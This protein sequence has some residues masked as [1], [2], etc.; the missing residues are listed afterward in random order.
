MALR[1]AESGP[2]DAETIVFLH[3]A[4]E[5]GAMWLPQMDALDEYHCLAPDL[6]GHGASRRTVWRSFQE[7]A[8]LVAELISECAPSGR[9][10]VVGLSLGGYLALELL[11]AHPQILDRVVVSGVHARP[12]PRARL[13]G[14]LAVLA[15]P[16]QRSRMAPTAFVRITRQAVR[17]RLPDLSGA[18]QPT[19]VVAGER[20]R[21]LIRDSVADVVAA[22]PD[23]A[24]GIVSGVGHLWNRESPELFNALVRGWLRGDALPKRL[25]M[26]P[27]SHV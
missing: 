27:Q 19:L 2:Q 26:L 6:P 3:G 14:L 16:M 11:A 13:V 1:I 25:A 24:G 5:S 15:A 7:S 23:A 18:S 17:Y 12:F 8:G 10:H 20:E 22:L 4:S 21:A 9:A